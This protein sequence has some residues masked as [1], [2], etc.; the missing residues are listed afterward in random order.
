[1]ELAGRPL[2]RPPAVPEGSTA[3]SPP[4]PST[5]APEAHAPTEELPP[6]LIL[7]P[8]AGLERRVRAGRDVDALGGAR[9]HAL[10]RL[11]RAVFHGAEARE[12]HLVAL[13]EV[14]ADLVQHGVQDCLDVLLLER[15]AF[16]HG[17]HEVGFR[18]GSRRALRHLDPPVGCRTRGAL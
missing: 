7:Q 10:S 8:L 6:S 5:D 1:G 2:S 11:A 14:R 4:T 17:A 18:D 16:G 12:L 3:T 13:A 9:A 15:R